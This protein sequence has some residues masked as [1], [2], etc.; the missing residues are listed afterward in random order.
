MKQMITIISAFA[1][2]YILY[3]RGFLYIQAKSA[4]TYIGSG[5]KPGHRGRS[6]IS[7]SGYVKVVLPLEKGKTYKFTLEKE[8]TNG[9]ITVE[10]KQKDNKVTIKKDN[11]SA[12][13]TVGKGVV[14]L[15]T[16]FQKASGVYRLKWSEEN[17]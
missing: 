8:L 4:V 11:G 10:I 2:L 3:I 6:V 1:I 7:C 17:E 12:V 15:T 9:N 14:R 16:H 5:R 13:F